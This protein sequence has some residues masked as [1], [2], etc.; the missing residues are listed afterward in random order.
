M[1]ILLSITSSTC[2]WSIFLQRMTSGGQM[3]LWGPPRGVGRPTLGAHQS[4]QATMI[5][6]KASKVIRHPWITLVFLLKGKRIKSHEFMGP[7]GCKRRAMV[8]R[9]THTH[10][11]STRDPPHKRGWAH[12]DKDMTPMHMTMFVAWYREVGGQQGCPNQ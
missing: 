12:I 5:H 8:K 6:V 1:S 2:T 9:S 11:T 10:S 4:P 7:Q 3:S